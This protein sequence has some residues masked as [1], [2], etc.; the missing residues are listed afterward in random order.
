MRE[1]ANANTD[2][3]CAA[4]RSMRRNWH[5]RCYPVAAPAQAKRN[6][7]SAAPSAAEAAYFLSSGLR[8]LLLAPRKKS[9]RHPPTVNRRDISGCE[10][11]TA[12]ESPKTSV[13]LPYNE[14]SVEVLTVGFGA[15]PP[16]S[17]P[18]RIDRPGN[19]TLER[20]HSPAGWRP[21]QAR[22]AN[23][24]WRTQQRWLKTATSG[25]GLWIARRVC[26]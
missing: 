12:A 9:Q 10:T 8:D 25:C 1:I 7:Q 17:S 13:S 18:H 11:K 15:T 2:R 22:I 23:R 20:L 4:V 24:K 14:T 6:H 16:S 21:K 5:S 3:T 26:E 19:A